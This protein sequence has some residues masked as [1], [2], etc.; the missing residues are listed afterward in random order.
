MET[1]LRAIREAR[2]LTQRELAEVAN[3]TKSFIS[4]VEDGS[5]FAN[6]KTMTKIADR[7]ECS[8]DEIA[9]RDDKTYEKVLKG[10]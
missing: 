6:F 2:G 5:K 7:L 1:N 4:R 8:L 9:M 10:A 3:V